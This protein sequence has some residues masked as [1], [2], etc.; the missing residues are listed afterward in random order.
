MSSMQTIDLYAVL[1]RRDRPTLRQIESVFELTPKLALAEDYPVPQYA[2]SARFILTSWVELRDFLVKHSEVD[3]LV[4]WEC[5]KL[6]ALLSLIFTSDGQLM[7]GLS[8][9]GQSLIDVMKVLVELVERLD[10]RC[11]LISE[12]D[13]PPLDVQEFR[14]RF[15]RETLFLT[16]R[17]DP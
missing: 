15:R 13:T 8:F 5:P 1:T 10:V 12:E 9:S 2:E 6:R 4:D 14:E 7:V 11:A 16:Y 17:T 3:Y